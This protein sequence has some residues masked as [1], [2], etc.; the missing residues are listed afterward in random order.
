MC[1]REEDSRTR[2]DVL[3]FVKTRRRGDIHDVRDLEVSLE[4]VGETPPAA[5]V[6]AAVL[7]FAAR[8][9]VDRIETFALALTAH[10]LE[11]HPAM[12]RVAANVVEREWARLMVPA[13][14]GREPH[15]RAFRDA[16]E[17]AWTTRVTRDRASATVES[18]V[19]DTLLMRV[20]AGGLVWVALEARWT[21]AETP[22]DWATDDAMLRDALLTAFAASDE[23]N[24][25]PLARALGRAALERCPRVARVRVALVARRC[26]PAQ[27]GVLVPASSA[28]KTVEV[29][30]TR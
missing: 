12:T 30:V 1:P 2:Q 14:G 9:P 22:R 10:V 20:T 26:D 15:A 21:W 23:V 24:L 25:E 16:G 13:A 28:G 8:D 18:G 17:E 4:P 19:R 7:G 6:R 3:R 5:A 11:K 29:T 27:E